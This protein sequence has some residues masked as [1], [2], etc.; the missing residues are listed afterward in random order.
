MTETQ[1][2]KCR[3]LPGSKRVNSPSGT[4]KRWLS[5]RRRSCRVDEGARMGILIHSYSTSEH[6]SPHPTQDRGAVRVFWLARACLHAL[7]LPASCRQP[8][9]PPRD[10]RA[11]R[12]GR[13]VLRFLGGKEF[14][15]SL[16]RE[17]S[18]TVA[19]TLLFLEKVDYYI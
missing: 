7:A 12:S 17:H 15:R 6:A 13:T 5:A 1:G 18:I 8:P 16:P 2:G 19:A 11:P 4:C 3:Q 9:P 10:P 14:Q